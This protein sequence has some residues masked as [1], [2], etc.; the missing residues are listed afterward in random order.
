MDTPGP[1]EFANSNLSNPNMLYKR[2]P[3][4]VCSRNL[5]TCLLVLH[6]L[7]STTSTGAANLSLRFELLKIIASC[8]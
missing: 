7:V 1:H 8:E 5:Y 3:N 4:G 2:R 6:A